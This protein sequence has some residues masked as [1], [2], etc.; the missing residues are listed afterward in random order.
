MHN[1]GYLEAL[2]ADR[3]RRRFAGAEESRL[4]HHARADSRAARRNRA[5]TG[6]KK[7]SLRAPAS[8]RRVLP[9]TPHAFDPRGENHDRRF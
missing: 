6:S 9:A 2:A 3:V 4:A 8:Q 1:Y 5:E 7:L